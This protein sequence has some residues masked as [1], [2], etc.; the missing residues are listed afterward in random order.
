[1]QNESTRTAP[2]AAVSSAESPTGFAGSPEPTT[3]ITTSDALLP[4]GDEVDAR[5]EESGKKAAPERL[6][7]RSRTG[8]TRASR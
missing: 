8:E 6:W 5:M 2:E 4:N 7:R 1:M 3:E